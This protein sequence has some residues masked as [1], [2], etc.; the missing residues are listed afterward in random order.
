MKEI[1]IGNKGHVALVDDDNY[2]TGPRLCL[3][4]WHIS[5]GYALRTKTFPDGTKKVTR[6]E[7]EVIGE[8]PIDEVVD[9]ANGNRLDNRRKNLRFATKH[10]NTVNANHIGQSE[11]G[12]L[13]VYPIRVRVAGKLAPVHAGYIGRLKNLERKYQTAVFECAIDAAKA[14]DELVFKVHGT[15]GVFN[16]QPHFKY[17]V[18]ILP[19]PPHRL[20]RCAKC[21]QK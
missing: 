14:R 3:F 8:P 5:K 10:Q 19:A 11:T 13:G 4:R 7:W 15:W 17:E 1:P 9:H 21:R 16:F 6:M 20:C 2:I 18:R 12:F